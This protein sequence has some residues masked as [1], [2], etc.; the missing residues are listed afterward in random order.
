MVILAIL[1]AF[2]N[3]D[4]KEYSPILTIYQMNYTWEHPY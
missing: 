2:G 3:R 4:L 1:V